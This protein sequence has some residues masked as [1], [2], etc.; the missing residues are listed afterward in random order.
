MIKKINITILVFLIFF[1]F[2]MIEVYADNIDQT[3]VSSLTLRYQY[4]DILIRDTGISIY[5]VA[6]I[7]EEAKFT[8]VSSFRDLNVPLEG[9]SASSWQEVSN[10]VYDYVESNHLEP[11]KRALTDQEGKVVFTDLQ[12]GL[13]LVVTDAKELG[14]LIYSS[15]PSLVSIPLL[16]DMNE[17]YLYDVDAN[18]K[19]EVTEV[20]P[21]ITPPNT[22]DYYFADAMLFLVFL[23]VS[24]IL[25]SYILKLQKK[26]RRKEN[27]KK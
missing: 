27:E 19:T 4:D 13:Y 1:G 7:D 26:E 18:V 22:M 21:E 17:E 9:D 23:L 11:L 5:Y 6:T 16:D 8:P 14:D 12:P 24:I 20:P 10:E 3:R 2:G 25:I 15:S